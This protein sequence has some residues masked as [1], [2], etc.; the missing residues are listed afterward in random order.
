MLKNVVIGM[1][2]IFLN[3]KQVVR[4]SKAMLNRALGNNNGNMA[5]NGEIS[6]IRQVLGRRVTED[7]NFVVFDVGANIGE[8]TASILDVA[9]SMG[10]K[11]AVHC[12]EPSPVTFSKL[13]AAMAQKYQSEK[14]VFCIN[15]GLGDLEGIME[16]YIKEE[17]SG[18]NSFYN[19]RLE[20]LGISYDETETVQVTTV[21]AYCRKES[22]PYID[23]LKVDVEGHEL[24]VMRGATGMLKKQAIDYIQFEYG[25]CWVDSRTLFLD[26]YDLLTSFGYI[27]GND[28]A[29]GN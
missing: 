26:M 14:K 1:I 10:G 28:N 15:A 3:R 27:I 8:Y 29:Q 9:E 4:L 24:A 18:I 11:L 25:G 2:D 17:G 6:L 23:F 7:H 5:T 22:I 19:R 16:L 21:D 20:R 12:F 13:K